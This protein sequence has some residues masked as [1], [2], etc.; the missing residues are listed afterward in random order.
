M[1]NIKIIDDYEYNELL[2]LYQCYQ[3]ILPTKYG[4]FISSRLL[5]E[6]LLVVDSLALG[7]YK[8]E[9]LVGY[10]IGYR[11][12]GT[13]TFILN[14]M[15]VKKQYR[16]YV[17]KFLDFMED[18]LK[19]NGYTCWKATALTKEANSSIVTY[20]AKPIEIKYYKEL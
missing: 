4:K 19:S 20:G 14:S 11:E 15:Y 12:A 6:E 9:V 2:D 16:F 8:N 3:D 7:L 17:K 1:I 13:K 18:Y 10:I 5:N